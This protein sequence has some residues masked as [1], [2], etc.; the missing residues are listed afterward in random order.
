MPDPLG[1]ITA[2]R[3]GQG[4][5]S[6]RIGPIPV[7]IHLSFLFVLAFLGLDLASPVLVAVWIV[8]GASSVLLH[9]LGHAVG[10]LLAGHE[11]QVDLAGMGGVTSYTPDGPN[12]DSRGWGLLITAA[13]PGIQILAGFALLPFVG[14]FGIDASHGLGTFA[15]SVWVV[16]SLLWGFLNLVPILP[17]D[18]GQLF[19]NLVPGGPTT[20]TRVAEVV[21]VAVAAAGLVWCLLNDQTIAALLAGWFGFANLQSLLRSP[22]PPRAS[23][24]AS[25]D[26]AAVEALQDAQQLQAE[27]EHAAS[28]EAAGRAASTARDRRLRTVGGSLALAGL[29]R[30][31]QHA[32]A[33][34]LVADPRHGLALN[35]VLVAHA[36]AAHPDRGAIASVLMA[37][38]DDQMEARLRGITA[39]TASLHGRPDVAD[40]LLDAGPV[41]DDVRAEVQRLVAE[42]ARG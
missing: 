1:P 14:R 13:G 8:V 21:S 3:R 18:G 29:L 31:D 33:Y 25:P 16:V 34:R 15:A 12:G 19:R 22:E 10:A 32:A 2:G 26:A 35:E 30:S 23:S 41:S 4:L 36:L 9:E 11:P 24:G 7:T 17:L 20:R 42:R 28:A 5:L 40:R 37:A 27:G 6:F 38:G 39:V